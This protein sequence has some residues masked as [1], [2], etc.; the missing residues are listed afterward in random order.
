MAQDNL[1][2]TQQNKTSG[3]PTQPVKVHDTQP[4][5]VKVKKPRRWRTA[6]LGILLVLLL[7]AAGD[8]KSVV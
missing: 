7:G 5:P 4:I 1:S 8:R 3:N 6:L 2:D